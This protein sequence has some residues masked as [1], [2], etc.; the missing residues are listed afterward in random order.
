VICFV[1]V[2]TVAR[3]YGFLRYPRL[4]GVV[5]SVWLLSAC[6]HVTQR[7]SALQFILGGDASLGSERYEAIKS[8]IAK[9]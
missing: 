1:R 5:W 6:H 4:F 2:F 9:E 3:F 8:F 7:G